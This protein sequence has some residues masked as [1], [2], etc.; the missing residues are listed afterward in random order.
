MAL[1]IALLV[2]VLSVP[3]GLK[4]N[5]VCFFHVFGSRDPFQ[6]LL[7]ALTSNFPSKMI[8]LD[9]YVSSYLIFWRFAGFVKLRIPF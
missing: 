4:P 5:F 1:L 7:Q 2:L 6:S 3:K 9:A 8:D